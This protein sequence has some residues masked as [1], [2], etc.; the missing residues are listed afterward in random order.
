M[1]ALKVGIAVMAVALGL[2]SGADVRAA[3]APPAASQPDPY[4][5]RPRVIVMTDI[6]NE[7]DDQM[8]LVRFLLYSN[9]LDVEGLVATTSTWMKSQVR[10]DVILSL[11]DA[12]ETVQPNLLRHAPGFPSAASLRSVVVAGQPGYGMAA[13]GPGRTSPGAELIVR[14]ALKADDRPLWVLGWGGANTLAQALVDARAGRPPAEV[15][16]IVAKLRVYTISDQDDAGAWIRRE[17]PALHYV[18]TPSTPNGEQY[19]FA[20]WTG[21]SGDRFYRNAPGAD[22]TTFS[23]EWVNANVRSKG[24]LGK[25]YP[26]PCCIHEG[27]TPSFLGLID[28]GLASAMSPAFGGWGGRYVWRQPSGESRAFWTQGGDSYPGRDSSR[29]TVVGADGKTYTSDQATIWRWRTA[30]QHDFAARMD[31]TVRAAKDANHN[32]RVVVNGQAGTAPLVLDAEVGRPVTLDAAGT[33]DPD[34]D[35]LKFTWFFYPEAGTGIPGQPVAVG[36]RPPPGTGGPPEIPPRIVIENANTPRATATPK[37]A[38]IAHVILAVEDAGTPSLTS[39]RRVILNMKAAPAGAPAKVALT[40]DDLP[41]HG[42]LPPGLTRRDIARSILAALQAHH[43]P[44]T[45]GFVNAKGLE[46]APENAEFLRLWRAAGHPL[47]NHTYSHMDLHASTPEAFERDVV[48]NEATLRSAMGD[49]GWRWLRYPYLREGDT[50]EKR[51]AV[52]AFLKERGYRV[53]E[54]TM[55]FDDYAYNDPYARC[56]A[57]NDTAG[58]DWLEESYLRRADAALTAGQEGARRVYGRDVAHVMLLHVGAFETVMFPK[59]LELLERRGFQL[60]T[61][62]EAESD[63]AYAIDPDRPSSGGAT[64]L[65]QMMAAK[66]LPPPAS[67]DALARIS[68]VCTADR[69]IPRPDENSRI[70]HE[71]LLEKK[72]K[73]R[74]DVYFLGDSIVRRWGTSDEKYKDL[75]ANWRQNFF[76]WNAANFGWGG[77]RTQNVLWRLDQ[78][79]LDGLHPQVIVLMIG[80]NNIGSGVPVGDDRARVDEVTRGVRQIVERCRSKAPEATIVLTGI[81]PRNDNLAVMPT[82]SRI[83]ANLA[84][85]ADGAAVRYLDI[86]D[87][88]ADGSGRL[89]PG[90]TD[91]DQLHLTVKAYQVWADALKPVLTELLGPPASVDRAPPPTG[92]PSAAPK[93]RP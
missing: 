32:P 53:A 41:V 33:A 45:Y 30:F 25:L 68:E 35:A 19:Y 73:G 58:V 23:D 57:G 38:G 4:V 92:D 24:P 8:S 64:L 17:F 48:A 55:S 36:R 44:P 86:N 3:D 71:Q 65:E 77:D 63:P 87:Q 88:L 74:I 61:L 40:F 91:P 16:A 62:E 89:F 7:P 46:G 83:N 80:T 43:A 47:G 59:L 22:F 26:F 18:A 2:A 42:P 21:I 49:E 90:M 12:Y 76:G 14:A 60:V 85:L 1:R 78:G 31:W 6:A 9:G 67:D 29:D 56:R 39:Y 28:N 10:P 84:R 11:V 52:A 79:E 75:L 70:A 5:A 50:L 37:A 69:P 13:V 72:T 81:T 20:T 66:G 54:V 82:I 27:D 93:A 51:R 15:E 34:G